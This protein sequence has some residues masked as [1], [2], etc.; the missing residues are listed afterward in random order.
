MTGGVSN[1]ASSGAGGSRREASL[2][3]KARGLMGREAL[4]PSDS[5]ALVM[6]SGG[7]DSLALLHILADLAGRPPGPAL[8]HAL[9]I[10]HH[11]RGVESD[12]DEALVIRACGELGV[13]L[14]VVHRPVAK[15]EGNVQET[16]RKARRGAALQVADERRCDR[17]ALGHTA[18]DQVETMLYRLG[19]YGGMAAFRGMLP[20]DPPWVRPLLDARRAETAAYCRAQGLVFAQDRGNAYPGYARTALREQVLAAWEA[21]LP[22]AVAAGARAAEVAAEVETLLDGLLADAERRVVMPRRGS[23]PRFDSGADGASPGPSSA[24][25][26][27]SVQGLAD[28][29]APLRRLLLHRWLEGRARPAASRASV[30]AL[31]SLMQVPGSA[32]RALGG[33]WRAMKEY[34]E[35]WIARGPRWT[36]TAPPDPVALP[37]PGR[38][39][40]GGAWVSARPVEQYRAP[41]IAREAFVDAQSL[42]GMV[43]VRGP[44]PGDRMRPLGAPGTRKLQDILV[45]L[46]VPAVLRA[47]VPL[48]VRNDRVLW[49]CGML[50]AEEGRI[51]REATGIVRLAVRWSRSGETPDGPAEGG[52]TEE[53][54]GE[55]RR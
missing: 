37:V 52:W 31:E 41:D 1:V 51:T 40:W 6:V 24:A 38:V 54:G 50:V 39:R 36:P 13:G 4:F 28:L 34:D 30:L 8:L 22:G 26:V 20:C 25:E 53:R 15:A 5:R 9:H 16:A 17:I 44:R 33:G 55:G 19:R 11:L 29:E 18:D 12:D 27:L 46:R 49:V 14:T 2:A 35:L 21:A 3:R 23:G 42:S 10:N 48:V 32:E 45:D 7:Q 43:E 47:R